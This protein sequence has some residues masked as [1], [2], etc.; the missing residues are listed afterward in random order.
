MREAVAEEAAQAEEHATERTR[1]AY[2]MRRAGEAMAA[3]KIK[4][5][6]EGKIHARRDGQVG[7]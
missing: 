2:K 3:E 7:G 4:W 6:N 1:W 5:V